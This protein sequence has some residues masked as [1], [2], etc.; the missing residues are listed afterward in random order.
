MPHPGPSRPGL[1]HAASFCLLA[2]N[3]TARFDSTSDWLP[4]YS[5]LAYLHPSLHAGT[6]ALDC[7]RR[8][9]PAGNA[10]PPRFWGARL[11]PSFCIYRVWLSTLIRQPNYSSLHAAGLAR[12]RAGN[13]SHPNRSDQNSKSKHTKTKQYLRSMS[14]LM[15]SIRLALRT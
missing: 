3:W 7:T 2:C 12:L 10:C 9:R 15:K 14:H 8:A 1:L 11:R 13:Q 5:E 6:R 4:A